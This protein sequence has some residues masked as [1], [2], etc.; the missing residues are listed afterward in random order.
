MMGEGVSEETRERRRQTHQ[1]AVEAGN[2]GHARVLELEC[3]K[4]DTHTISS[5][6]HEGAVKG[7][8]AREE[9][10]VSGETS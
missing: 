6:L 3:L 4:S 8:A 2:D 9:S 1:S 7:R 5:G 10:S